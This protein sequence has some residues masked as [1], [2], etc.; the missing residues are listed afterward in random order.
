MMVVEQ[1]YEV[2]SYQRGVILPASLQYVFLQPC[3]FLGL[4][5]ESG[6]DDDEGPHLLL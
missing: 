1:S 6:R 5:A 3:P 2:W 4:L